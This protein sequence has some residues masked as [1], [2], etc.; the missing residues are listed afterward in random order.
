[1]IVWTPNLH[2]ADAVTQQSRDRHDG[3]APARRYL[4]HFSWGNR[5]EVIGADPVQL[6]DEIPDRGEY[7]LSFAAT[8]M[9]TTS[10]T[11]DIALLNVAPEFEDVGRNKE[12]IEL[13]GMSA[14]V[15]GGVH[16]RSSLPG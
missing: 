4:D 12:H 10:L 8:G 16:I 14:G 3:I 11:V 7:R 2:M 5:S 15:L 6:G 13:D 1:M 9:L